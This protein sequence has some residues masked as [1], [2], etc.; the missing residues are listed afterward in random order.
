MSQQPKTQVTPPDTA[1]SAG[2]E[3]G[4]WAVFRSNALYGGADMFAAARIERV[5]AKLVRANAN[6]RSQHAI[7]DVLPMPDEASAQELVAQI[8]G[9][10]SEAL[11]REIAAR[12]WCKSEVAK[13]LFAA[14]SRAGKSS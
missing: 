10:Q 13:L 7:D 8:K 2:L 9:K 5:S 3:V 14:L 11:R 4:G 1:V 6:H 12:D